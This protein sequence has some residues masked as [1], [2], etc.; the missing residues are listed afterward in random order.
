MNAILNRQDEAQWALIAQALKPCTPRLQLA[1]IEQLG[2]L[3]KFLKLRHQLITQHLISNYKLFAA[4]LMKL[5][6]RPVEQ[7]GQA[8]RKSGKNTADY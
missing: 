2:S 6:G 3:A 1:L 8:L 7:M 4:P 5:S